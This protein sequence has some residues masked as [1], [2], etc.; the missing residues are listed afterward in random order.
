LNSR[1]IKPAPKDWRVG[2]QCPVLGNPSSLGPL[3]R[4]VELSSPWG[5]ESNNAHFLPNMYHANLN[6]KCYYQRSFDIK[7]VLP[8]RFT[9]TGT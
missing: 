9:S 1:K 4:G 6:V 3:R 7:A 8:P 5:F 2:N